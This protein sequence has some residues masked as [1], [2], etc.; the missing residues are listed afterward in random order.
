M[1]KPHNFYKSNFW[2]NVLIIKNNKK[3][4]KKIISNLRKSNIEARPIWKANHLQKPYRKYQKYKIEKAEKIT[5][6]YICLPSSPNLTFQEQKKIYKI[7][8]MKK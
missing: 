3:K 7:I 6:S 1:L 4:L 8:N 5:N 2:L